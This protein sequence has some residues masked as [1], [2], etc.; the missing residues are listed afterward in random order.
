VKLVVSKN[1]IGSLCRG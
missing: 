1:W